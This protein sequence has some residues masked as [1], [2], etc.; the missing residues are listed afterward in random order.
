M[1]RD[2]VKRG[3]GAAEVLKRAAA[4]FDFAPRW[5]VEHGG[6]LA[7]LVAHYDKFA[8]VP[9]GDLRAGRAAPANE[10]DFGGQSGEVPL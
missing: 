6:D 5:P 3:G 2:L 7:T 9:A 1:M 4:M 10:D 8:G